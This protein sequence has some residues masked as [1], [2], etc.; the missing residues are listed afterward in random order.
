MP[1]KVTYTARCELCRSLLKLETED[2]DKITLILRGEGWYSEFQFQ[3][4][5]L[6]DIAVCKTCVKKITTRV[7]SAR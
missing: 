5:K 2:P 4:S 6:P 3:C 7:S 1:I